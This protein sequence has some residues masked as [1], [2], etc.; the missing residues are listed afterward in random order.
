MDVDTP[1]GG[2]KKFLKFYLN[3]FA[4]CPVYVNVLSNDFAVRLG[5]A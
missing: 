5:L 3:L 4:F 2:R 1:S